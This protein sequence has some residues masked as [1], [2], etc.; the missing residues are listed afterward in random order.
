MQARISKKSETFV[1]SAIFTCLIL[2]RVVFSRATIAAILIL[3]CETNVFES[4]NAE[5]L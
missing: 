1:G 4:D 2:V 3:G 5:T